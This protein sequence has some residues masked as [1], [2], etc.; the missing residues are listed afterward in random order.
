[1]LDFLRFSDLGGL[2]DLILLSRTGLGELPTD[3]FFLFSF[4]FGEL[5]RSLLSP[6]LD[7][8]R[9]S[10]LGGLV[11]LPMEALL[12]FGDRGTSRPNMSFLPGSFSPGDL[13]GLGVL[14]LDLVL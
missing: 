12:V 8:L 13:V 6:M 9:F 3:F 5:D 10:D 2:V 1:M 7:F 11:D 4:P 14:S